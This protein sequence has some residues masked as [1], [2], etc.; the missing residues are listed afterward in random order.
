MEV[1]EWHVCESGF[2]VLSTLENVEAGAY[3]AVGGGLWMLCYRQTSS[4][5]YLC[6]RGTVHVIISL[7]TNVYVNIR[8]QKRHGSN[9]VTCTW[10]EHVVLAPPA[11]MALLKP[12]CGLG[13][14]AL[15]AA[16]IRV[17]SCKLHMLAFKVRH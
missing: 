15:T 10:H 8:L 2:T 14:R 3:I 17:V 16:V 6:N 4:D 9:G 11:A 1:P 7:L 12:G 13:F 5:V